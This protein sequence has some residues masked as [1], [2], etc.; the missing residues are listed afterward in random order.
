M[1]EESKK[2]AIDKWTLGGMGLTGSRAEWISQYAEAHSSGEAAISNT[3]AEEFPSLLPIAMK[4]SAQ[5]ISADLVSVVPI[6]GGNTVEEMEAIRKDVKIENRDRK[7]E[8]IVEGKDFEEMKAEDHPGYKEPVGPRGELFYMDFK[9]GGT[10][11]NM[12]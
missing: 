6:G 2:A 5:T 8:S 11:S 3:A 12:P 1:K 4:I 10:E 7:I 9:Y